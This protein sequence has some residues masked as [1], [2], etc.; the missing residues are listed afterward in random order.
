[1][2]V[3]I[4]VEEGEVEGLSPV[5]AEGFRINKWTKPWSK[6]NVMK[7]FVFILFHDEPLVL[8][9]KGKLLQYPK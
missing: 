2:A 1:M 8:S 5:V 4:S 9:F 3:L 6:T 7:Y